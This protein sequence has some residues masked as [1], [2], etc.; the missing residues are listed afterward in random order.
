ML[1]ACAGLLALVAGYGT[2][3]AQS[4]PRL[5]VRQFGWQTNG[6]VVAASWNP[7][8]VRVT[9]SS[10][11]DGAARVQVI[12]KVKLTSGSQSIL[13]PL[14]A[15]AQEVALPAGVTK[16]V[17]LWVPV[18]G[19]GAYVATVQVLKQDGQVLNE[20]TAT[21][22]ATRADV[23]LVGALAD[24]S[25]LAAQL[26][27]VEVPYQQG[28]T[29]Q[30]RTVELQSASD[31]PAR[32]EY[33]AAFRAVAVQGSTAATLT[34]EQRTALQDWVVQ[35]GHLLIVGG[36]DG[37]RAASVLGGGRADAPRLRFSGVD[38]SAEL[39]PLV[40]WATG[41]SS[42][43]IT[44]PAARIEATATDSLAGPPG[45]PLVVRAT[46]GDGS[47][48]LLGPDPT[49]DPLRSWP[50]TPALLKRAL[51][52]AFVGG[53]SLDGSARSPLD[54]SP[55]ND[56][57]RL[58]AALDAL[59]P[60]VFPDW[61]HV[62]LLLG[63]FAL[64]AGPLLHALLWRAD[65]RPWLWA[66]V[67]LLSVAF[68]VGIY[69]FA[70]ATPGRD[71]VANAVSEVRL[72][73][74]TGA[75]RQ[76][77]AVGYFAPLRDQLTVRTPGE[78][79]VRV[80]VGSVAGLQQTVSS[81]TFGPLSGTL[82]APAGAP[83]AGPLYRVITGRDTQVEFGSNAATSNNGGGLRSLVMTRTLPAAGRIETDLRVEGTDSIIKGTVRNSTPYALDEV[84]LAV[85]QT[86]AKLGPLAPGQTAAVSFDPRLP[87]PTTSSTGGFSYS[88]GWQ[89]YG[90]PAASLRT[91]GVPIAVELPPDP[92][93]HRRVKVIETVL[94][95]GDGRGYSGY[96]PPPPYRSSSPRAPTLVAVT[97]A[98]IG[99]DTIPTS[100]A[101]RT[102]Q[103]TVLEQPVQLSIAA[104]PFTL[105]SVLLPPAVSVGSGS[106]LS[107]NNTGGGGPVWQ[108]L[109]GGAAIYS[110]QADLPVGA[111]VDSMLVKTRET[112]P[113]AAPV[114]APGVAIAT[115]T[116]ASGPST[117]GTFSVFNWQTATWEPLKAGET[118]A[119]ISPAAALV[120]PN[121]AVRILVNSGGANR[122][123]RFLAPEL[124]MQGEAP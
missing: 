82:G 114:G 53:R 88:I 76:S 80:W 63:G 49:L 50:S 124:V 89:M 25:T 41:A 101:Q 66:A 14:S 61:Q 105:P 68:T 65:R 46:W 71:V 117:P 77:L 121:G 100:G 9:G 16:D 102:F 17:K 47:V 1:L 10:E 86:Y 56:E 72:D 32:P 55:R 43:S 108:D 98:A 18:L 118:Q 26:A 119:T 28:L 12:L 81:G 51:E 96:G 13:Y 90:V 99:G 75:G 113:V 122:T 22:Q 31:L 40:E 110:F 115:R 52:P 30:L 45:S 107:N 20:Q 74:R 73:P 33:L 92:D 19:D 97:S 35:G 106:T 3:I 84:G 39:R 48:T 123:V 58:V 5:E 83:T 7:V 15:H 8:A 34:A 64:V 78:Q 103:L 57:F 111:R 21:A 116:D 24:S 37:A 29:A 11:T 2:A 112:L 70:G 59:P 67:P 4:G 104:G 6:S 94:A 60:E 91:A 109:R 62:G 95:G 36:P 44:G 87:P 54:P 23:P 42:A 93:I 79:P 27:R 120:S 69:L 85:G 38:G